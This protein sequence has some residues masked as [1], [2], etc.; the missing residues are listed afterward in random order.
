MNLATATMLTVEEAMEIL[1]FTRRQLQYQV[2]LG[3]IRQKKCTRRTI[4][5]YA[6]SVRKFLGI[7]TPKPVVSDWAKPVRS[8]WD[9]PVKSGKGKRV[10]PIVNAASGGEVSVAAV[11]V[12]DTQ[13]TAI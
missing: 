5:I 9:A 8:D 7:E 3:E 1:R 13:R 10:G 12:A 6:D 2:D 11:G 4:L